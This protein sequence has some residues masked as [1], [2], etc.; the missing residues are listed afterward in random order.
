MFGDSTKYWLSFFG[1]ACISSL[2]LTGYNGHLA[3]PYYPFLAAAAGHLA[4]QISTVDLSDK[5]DCNRKFVS[6][7]WFGAFVFGGIL[8]GVLAS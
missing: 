5:S 4:W 3:C 6:N 1:S 7:K 2:A 8:C